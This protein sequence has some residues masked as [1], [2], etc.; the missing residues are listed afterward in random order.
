[1]LLA[2]LSDKA[3]RNPS[4][5]TVTVPQV[6]DFELISPVSRGAYGRVYKVRKRTTG[7]APSVFWVGLWL[8]R[9]EYY[10]SVHACQH[11]TGEVLWQAS[12]VA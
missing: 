6:S 12:K 9:G 5:K 4:K 7:E 10:S 2:S 1:V 8:H 3:E 11:G